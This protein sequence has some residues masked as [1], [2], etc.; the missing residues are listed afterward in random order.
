[1][2]PSVE[3]F[4]AGACWGSRAPPVDSESESSRSE[5]SGSHSS[6]MA[7]SWASLLKSRIPWPRSLMPGFR[8]H[9]SWAS[10]GRAAFLAKLSCSS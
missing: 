8:I 2:I 9:H 10:G 1:M 4:A 7:R 6:K 5:G 3:G